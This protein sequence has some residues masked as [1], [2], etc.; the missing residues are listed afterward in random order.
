MSGPTVHC[1]RGP[2][3]SMGSSDRWHRPRPCS[4]AGRHEA[5][6]AAATA[7][8]NQGGATAN[9]DEAGKLSRSIPV[10]PAESA[11]TGRHRGASLINTARGLALRGTG[12]RSFGGRAEARAAAHT[13][14]ID[15][16]PARAI[17][18]ALRAR[19]TGNGDGLGEKDRT[20]RR[21]RHDVARDHR[22]RL[23]ASTALKLRGGGK[24]GPLPPAP[25]FR[26]SPARPPPRWLAPAPG[27][28]GA[29][30]GRQWSHP[31]SGS[32]H[33]HAPQHD[34]SCRDLVSRRRI[35]WRRALE[36]LET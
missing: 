24:K 7:S 29:A 6:E 33:R 13:S 10:H 31:H 28:V 27:T 14:T 18:S 11:H 16:D 19:R 4:G 15:R 5:G 32:S 26:R 35:R 23:S 8:R 2:A 25:P 22:R 20:V 30:R 21:E 1:G 34:A 3:I 17:T 12:A 36:P 9:E